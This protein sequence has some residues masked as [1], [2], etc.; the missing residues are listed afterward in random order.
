MQL[1][2]HSGIAT[3]MPT[4]RHHREAP[5]PVLS[6]SDNRELAL[7][8]CTEFSFNVASIS[9]PSPRWIGK[10]MAHGFLGHAMAIR[11]SL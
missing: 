9:C 3:S 1:E 10:K 7:T 2:L 8:C 4:E 11:A 6:S 5:S